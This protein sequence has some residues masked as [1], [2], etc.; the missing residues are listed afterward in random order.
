[1]AQGWASLHLAAFDSKISAAKRRVLNDVDIHAKAQACPPLSIPL[2][3]K[4]SVHFVCA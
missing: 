3:G 4:A 1:M 2:A